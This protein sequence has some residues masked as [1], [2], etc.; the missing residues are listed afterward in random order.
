MV[1][2]SYSNLSDLTSGESPTFGRGGKRLSRVVT[3]AGVL[4]ELDDESKSSVGS[5]APSSVSQE[6]MIIVGNQLPLRAHR[7]SEV[8]IF[9]DLETILWLPLK[10]PIWVDGVV[11]KNLSGC[12]C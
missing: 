5:D 9:E 12:L 3:F 8:G 10:E 4:S 7:R 2:R 6:R 11:L 1:S